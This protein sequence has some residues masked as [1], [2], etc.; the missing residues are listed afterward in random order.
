MSSMEASSTLRWI[1]ITAVAPVSWGATYWVTREYLPAESPLWGA[2]VRALPAGLLLLA[3]AR[4]RPTGAWWWRAAVLGALNF[5]GFFVLVYVA[6]QLLPTSLAASVMALAPVTL[7]GLGWMLLGQRPTGAA[8]LGASLGI[9]GVVLVVGLSTTKVDP[10]GVA[11]SLSAL[12]MSSLGAILTTRWRD[13]TPVVTSTAWQLTAGGAMLILAAVCVEGA[14]PAVAAPGVVAYTFVAVV[15]TAAAFLCW[16]AGLRHLAPATVGT[17]GLL[18]PVTG[19]ALG[20]LIAGET[21]TNAQAIG[22][23]LVLIGIAVGRGRVVAHRPQRGRA[24]RERARRE[25]T[26]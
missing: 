24:P 11:V 16:F 25:A 8:V 19:I 23:A 2:A 7:A 15:A 3:V 17:V 5:G 4:R 14:P 9:I 18:N 13:D 22:V 10:R 26:C 21:L 20:T 12:L 1:M 6:A